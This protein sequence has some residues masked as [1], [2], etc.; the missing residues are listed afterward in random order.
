MKDG[1]DDPGVFAAENAV[2]A[3]GAAMT[4]TAQT[5]NTFAFSAVIDQISISSAVNGDASVTF[6]FLM[7]DADGVT[8]AWS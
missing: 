7:A 6:N 3:D 2:S 1:S 8:Q 4:L 5:G